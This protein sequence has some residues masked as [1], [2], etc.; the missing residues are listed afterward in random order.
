MSIGV[1]SYYLIAFASNVF[2]TNFSF[3]N[4][5]NSKTMVWALLKDIFGIILILLMSIWK[6]EYTRATEGELTKLVLLMSGPF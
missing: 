6:E 4:S 2:I 5:D 3:L 1:I